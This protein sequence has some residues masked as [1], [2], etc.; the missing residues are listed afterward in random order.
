MLTSPVVRS[1][2]HRELASLDCEFYQYFSIFYFPYMRQDGLQL[3]ISL[4]S[5][6]LDSDKTAANQA[7]VKQFYLRI[8][9]KI[10]IPQHVFKGFH[11]LSSAGIMKIF[12]FLIF[13]V[14][15]CMAPGGK[16]YI[17][18]GVPHEW[19]TWSFIPSNFPTLSLQQSINYKESFPTLYWFLWK[20]LLMGFLSSVLASLCTCLSP[21][22][23]GQWGGCCDIISVMEVRRVVDFAVF[24]TLEWSDDF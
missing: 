24:Y 8:G 7:L 17:N 23:E 16:T 1:Q 20:L 12:F 10:R 21:Q 6:R 5:C 15:I 18:V 13:T 4:P 11:F 3:H 14:R 19:G 9:L 22:F 2:S